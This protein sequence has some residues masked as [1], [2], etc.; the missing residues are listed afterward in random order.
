[1]NW[2]KNTF[3]SLKAT[4]PQKR[5][6]MY[7]VLLLIFA[8]YITACIFFLIVG[9]GALPFFIVT[10]LIFVVVAGLLMLG[11]IKFKSFGFRLKEAPGFN[12]RDFWRYFACASAVLIVFWLLKYPGITS[13]DTNYQWEQATTFK[14][15][16]WHP[17]MHTLLISV[18]A[19]IFR[20]YQ[21]VLLVQNLIMAS[22]VAYLGAELK[23]LGF[24]KWAYRSC[25]FYI[26]L[27]PSTLSI[28]Q[29]L[30]KDTAFGIA[31]LFFTIHL[32]DIFLSN[33]KWL[34]KPKNVV[35]F[36][37]SF[38]AVSFMRH[39]GIFASFPILVA[40]LILYRRELLKRTLTVCCA[41]VVTFLAIKFPFYSLIGIQQVKG[42]T[43]TESVGVPMTILTDNYMYARETMPADAADMISKLADE[44][45]WQEH[46]EQGSYN[47][48][49][50]YS[51]QEQVVS[52]TPLTDLLG[53][54]AGCLAKN[55]YISW[56]AVGKLT[57]MVY[58]PFAKVDYPPSW[59]LT[60]KSP[61][62]ESL[63]IFGKLQAACMNV[64]RPFVQLTKYT[65]IKNFVWCIGMLML[66][67]LFA[68]FFSFSRHGF[69]V[70]LLAGPMFIY[71]IGTMLMLCGNDYRFF[72]FNIPIA[73]PV[74]FTLLSGGNAD[75]LKSVF[76]KFKIRLEQWG[77]KR[78]KA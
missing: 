78:K 33:G 6:P 7:I 9:A 73:L 58:N 19:F 63:G 17:A 65:P 5:R 56:R 14:I 47:S 15:N 55:P 37:L 62:N 27:N 42:Q 21:F 60:M 26:V 2:L 38:T 23:G 45:T 70:F 64:V 16:D 34:L 54:T 46:Y 77:K 24:P 43:Y 57:D 29:Y 51:N 48:I 41:C 8:I 3:D 32:I 30:W 72:Y 49:K 69:K 50:F 25:M 59:I 22:G 75:K 71:N 13:P 18:F 36:T 4:V 12:W 28:M 1:M 11:T 74:I 53:M 67:M 20:K 39:N 61:V 66:L 52:Q 76:C 35:F 40:L 31:M 44:S 10:L 68:A